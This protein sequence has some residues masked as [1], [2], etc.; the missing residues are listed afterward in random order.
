[1]IAAWRERRQVGG[2]SRPRAGERLEARAE[3]RQASDKAS[4]RRESEISAMYV[5][6]ALQAVPSTSTATLQAVPSTSTVTQSPLTATVR[7]T[8]QRLRR[9]SGLSR[10]S[11]RLVRAVRRRLAGIRA[12]WAGA[13][14]PAPATVRR[15]AAPAQP[16]LGRHGPSRGGGGAVA[17][18][19]RRAARAA[20]PGC[21]NSMRFH[22]AA[23]NPRL[24]LLTRTKHLGIQSHSRLP[25]GIPKLLD[26]VQNC[27]NRKEKSK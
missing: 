17:T 3:A 19:E 10:R 8:P 15:N 27:D 25:A 20:G 6:F 1:M 23:K 7:L 9:Q 12:T 2:A 16:L 5:L 26:H 11:R 13:R 22:I 14:A 4:D 18:R 21:P 24:V